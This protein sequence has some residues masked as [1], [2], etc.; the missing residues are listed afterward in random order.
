MKSLNIALHKISGFY[1]APQLMLLLLL[2]IGYWQISTFHFSLKYD[3]IDCYYPWRYMVGEC[4][5]NGM[6][7]WWNP[8]QTLGY[9]L[10][11]DPQSGAWYPIAWIIGGIWGYDI[12]SLEFE[13]LLHVFMAGT[14]MY[15][16]GRVLCLTKGASFLIASAYMFSGFIIG[17][18]Q[19]FT[20]IISAAWIP[21]IISYYLKFT[22]SKKYTDAL[23]TGFFMYLLISGGYPAFAVILCYFLLLLFIYFSTGTA[24]RKEWRNLFQ[25]VK[26]N[27]V[28]LISALLFSAVVLVSV[29]EVTAYITRGIKLP[30]EVAL[31][32]PLSPQC[33]VSFVLPFAAIKDM[34]FFNTDLSMTNIYFGLLIFIFF[35]FSLFIKKSS[36]VKVFFWWGIFCLAAALGE[37]LPVRKLL[38]D[39][40]PMM[41][42]FRFPS[43]FRLFSIISFLIAAGFAFDNYFNSFQ[44]KKNILLF[45]LFPLLLFLMAAI[46]Y[47]RM[48]GYLTITDFI[49]NDLFISSERSIIWQHIAFQSAVQILFLIL[50]VLV[51]LKVKDAFLKKRF[52]I[53][54][55]C[56]DLIFA[57][58]LNEPYTT[59]SHIFST[60][61]TKEISNTFP[62]GFPLPSLKHVLMCNDTSGLSKGTFWK[63]MN[64]FHK[65][66][67]WDGFTPFK[68]KG[69]ETMIDSFPAVFRNTLSNP[70]VFLSDKIFPSD[71][72]KFHN[73]YKMYD[74]Q[75]IYID[76]AEVFSEF[77][78]NLNH[79]SADTVIIEKFSPSEIVLKTQT[80]DKQLLCLLQNY[81]Q[82]WAASI[83][84]SPCKIETYSKGLMCV[85]IPAGTSKVEFSYHNN[86]ILIA[87]FISL[88]SLLLFFLVMIIIYTHRLHL[89]TGKRPFIQP[90]NGP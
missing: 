44:K 77:K 42:F 5:Q 27:F 32:N 66:V 39:Y 51:L 85:L 88:F 15:F 78:N 67:A 56:A 69:Y 40:L 2:I 18:A 19:H 6:L 35:I 60:K 65:Q 28:F 7:P 80:S 26:L 55:A 90:G 47:S 50:M 4:L 11:A 46:V 8:Y 43:L 62:V 29:T 52:F 14:G 74:H 36:L 25:Y 75:N 45:I 1:Y 71:S 22:N 53:I 17:N 41:G 9:P 24:K 30:L 61:N 13:F 12:Y 68:F 16:L 58:W 87:A 76:E 34:A 49:K 79:N 73:H 54:I 86:K 33:L 48:K 64:I 38:Y 21:Y 31:F 89:R 84:G 83:N 20:W 23:I 37:Y 72:M 3:M 57:S 63:N 70:P 82:G 81:Y 10:H 59:Y